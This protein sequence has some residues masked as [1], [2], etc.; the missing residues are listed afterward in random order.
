MKNRSFQNKE[1]YG[2]PVTG[3]RFDQKNEMFKRPLWDE[4]LME[5]GQRFYMETAIHDKP[6]WRQIEFAARNAAWNVAI[7]YAG[8]LQSNFGMYSWE[9]ENPMAEMF[10][11]AAEKVKASSENMS[12]SVKRMASFFGAGLVGICR[13][14]PNWIYSHEYHTL[15][16][17]H[18]PMA[19]PEGC[20]N[21]VVMAIEMDYETIKSSSMVLQGTATGLGYSKMAFVAN[22]V[23]A[24]IRSLGYRAIP[25]GN[26]TGLSVPLALAAGLGEWS[27]MGL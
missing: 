6:G 12:A 26:D 16:G 5:M 1:D 10:K 8:G 11:Q 17:T 18:K 25:S 3:D 19:L 14:H 24:F 27:R 20:D 7:V 15:E 4:K 22:S 13:V 23:A 21:A 9:E 2:F